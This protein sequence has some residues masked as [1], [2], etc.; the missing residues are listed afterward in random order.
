MESYFFNKSCFLLRSLYLKTGQGLPAV[1]GHG[2]SAALGDYSCFH[3]ANLRICFVNLYHFRLK[4][5]HLN[6]IFRFNF[7]GHTSLPGLCCL[8]FLSKSF[9]KFLNA[10]DLPGR[11]GEVI[12]FSKAS[13]KNEGFL[14]AEL[15][16][17]PICS[18]YPTSS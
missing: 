18:L 13:S 9:L 5:L 7:S 17:S 14:L 16:C 8:V 10:I 4:D 11:E 2:S 15:I 6:P 12:P 1:Q 3:S